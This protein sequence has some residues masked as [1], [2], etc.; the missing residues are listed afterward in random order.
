M[1]K[2]LYEGV[3]GRVDTSVFWVIELLLAAL[4]VYC[5]FVA[6]KLLLII[7]FLKVYHTH[8]IP[9]SKPFPSGSDWVMY[10][11]SKGFERGESRS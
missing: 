3:F 1:Q 9:I 10:W 11:V 6:L 4:L 5:F 7:Y 2:P 8:F